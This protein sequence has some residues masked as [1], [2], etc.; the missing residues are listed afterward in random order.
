MPVLNFRCAGGLR[1]VRVSLNRGSN[2]TCESSCRGTRYCDGAMSTDGTQPTGA[3]SRVEVEEP[4]QDDCFVASDL[5]R[6]RAKR[7]IH[8]S[9]GCLASMRSAVLW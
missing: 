6:R 1:F 7:G 3:V 2:T 8:S 4:R 9:L 5:S